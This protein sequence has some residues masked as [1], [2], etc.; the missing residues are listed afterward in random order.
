MAVMTIPC[1]GMMSPTI[2]DDALAA[3]AKGALVIGCRG[4]DCQLQ[5]KKKADKIFERKQNV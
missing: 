1:V 5:G 3:G 2:L 4:L